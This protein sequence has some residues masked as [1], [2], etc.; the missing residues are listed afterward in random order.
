MIIA[1]SSVWIQYLKHN[2][3]IFSM[4]KLMLEKKEILGLECIFAE[5]LQGAK[6]DKEIE[7]IYSYWKNIPKVNEANMWMQ[8]GIY[9]AKNKLFARN[10]GIFD[11]YLITLSRISKSK[12]WT[13]DKKFIKKLDND[14]IY[15]NGSS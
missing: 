15:R 8:A 12:I 14:L 4:M 2:P 7:I 10:I 5:L 1:D 6:D 11:S 3:D 9:A 13:L